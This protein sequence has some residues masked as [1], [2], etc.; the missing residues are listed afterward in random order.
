MTPFAGDLQG[1]TLEL[2]YYL[3]N[4]LLESRNLILE[5]DYESLSFGFCHCFGSKPKSQKTDN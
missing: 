3:S 1:A 5:L 2:R 4:L